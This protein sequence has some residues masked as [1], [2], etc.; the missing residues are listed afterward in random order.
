MCVA[1]HMHVEEESSGMESL[2]FRSFRVGNKRNF[3]NFSSYF[4][5]CVTMLKRMGED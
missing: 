4:G 1:W 5:V 3:Y 2:I